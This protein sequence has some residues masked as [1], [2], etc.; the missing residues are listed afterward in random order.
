VRLWSGRAADQ[1]A[2]RAVGLRAERGKMLDAMS[3]ESEL[4]D[5]TDALLLTDNDDFNALAALALRA[6]LGHG[7]VYRAAPDRD[8]TDL[9]A[10]AGE[11]G[12]LG[13]DALTSAELDRRFAAGARIVEG[14]AGNGASDGEAALF[15]VT[16]G[17]DL[18]VAC[19]GKSL[20]VAAG[21][22]V[23]TLVGSG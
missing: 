13:T 4:E 8:E 3:R 15:V 1:E 11:Q 20:P 12:I 21:D 14:P 10:P 5:V 7:R 22:R 16:A 17:G 9:L 2:A 6:E 19:A 18:R 23:I